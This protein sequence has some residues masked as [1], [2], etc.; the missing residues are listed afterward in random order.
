MLKRIERENKKEN[1]EYQY[2]GF[3]LLPIFKVKKQHIMINPTT[4]C[5]MFVSNQKVK[6][7]KAL[8]SE[9]SNSDIFNHFLKY[10]KYKINSVTT[11]G[12]SLQYQIVD[13]DSRK[14]NIDDKIT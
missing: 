12:I 6:T 13:L 5:E 7:F 11:D 3:R 9:A 14:K 10:R 8:N 4:F 2:R 1:Q